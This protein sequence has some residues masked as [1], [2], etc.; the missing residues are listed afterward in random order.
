MALVD[1]RVVPAREA[2]IPLCD[3]GFLFGDSVY[4][5]MRTF[6]GR[7]FRLPD[8]L[9]RLRE[10]AAGLR[11]SVPWSDR[12][13]EEQI[14]GF[15]ARLP[16]EEHY[17]R[18]IVSRGRGHLTYEPDPHQRPR[19]VLLGGPLQPLPREQL[20]QGLKAA[21]VSIRRTSPSSLNPGLKTGNLLNARLAF[22]EAR[23]RGADEAILL[24]LQGE[25]AE[26]ATSNLF[27]V[28]PGGVLA[29]PSVE[30]GLLVGVTR[31]VVLELARQMGIPV[32][33]ERLPATCLEEA[34]EAFL[35]STTRSICCIRELDG[36]PLATPGPLTRRLIEAF[37]AHAGGL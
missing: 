10:S 8:H 14:E 18:L 37:V 22:L 25:V 7:L 21:V 5:T 6:R 30:S 1:G 16:G 20:E 28:L 31:G 33:E 11:L 24:N 26:A 29:T 9:Q 35:T 17:L 13:I 34:E 23:E 4:E 3:H 2:R 27:L 32:R 12:Q 15:R 36:R 19:M